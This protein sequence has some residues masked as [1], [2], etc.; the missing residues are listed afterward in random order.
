ML[1]ERLIGQLCGVLYWFNPL[2]WL[3][4][5]T[6]TIRAER[7]CDNR[8]L[9]SGV[10]PPDYA[11]PLLFISRSVNS[12]QGGRMAMA[13][14]S[15]L[16]Q[17]IQAVLNDRVERRPPARWSIA[18]ILVIGGCFAVPI[19]VTET[20]S[21][22]REDAVTQPIPQASLPT[23]DDTDMT[24]TGTIFMP[25]GTPASGVL[26]TSLKID[27]ASTTR[28]DQQGR[29][30]LTCETLTDC[31]L[32]TR[33]M[34]GG[35]QAVRRIPA[36]LARTEFTKPLELTLKKAREQLV[37]VVAERKPVE[38]CQ[39]T[40]VGENFRVT[41]VTGKDGRA[42]LLVPADDRLYHVFALDEQLGADEVSVSVGKTPVA[43]MELSLHTP[44]RHTLRVVDATGKPVSD[45]KL[46][47]RTVS[48]R[49]L[50]IQPRGLRAANVVSDSSGQVI[51]PWIPTQAESVHVDVND[52][53]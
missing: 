28:T 22:A 44:T 26:V 1:A 15:R 3:T 41:G 8:V 4:L 52:Q 45:V 16:R 49:G 33:T 7:A 50:L 5:R 39:L 35:Y 2:A 47:V 40:A 12:R 20:T 29:F 43:Y 31:R 32:H 25:D 18:V 38:G 10:R 46:A 27:G 51:L 11:E 17:R 37:A 24:L 6:A 13:R 14:S 19:V 34:D 21:I 9:R 48:G 23:P 42:N 53:R 36:L 30:Q